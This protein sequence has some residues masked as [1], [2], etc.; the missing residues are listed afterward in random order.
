MEVPPDHEPQ[1]FFKSAFI[2]FDV[3]RAMRWVHG[4]IA[5]F[6]PPLPQHRISAKAVCQIGGPAV[7]VSAAG[8]NFLTET[9][10]EMFSGVRPKSH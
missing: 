9:A 3:V 4:R 6:P 10:L 8:A 1:F 7:K 2:I 5:L